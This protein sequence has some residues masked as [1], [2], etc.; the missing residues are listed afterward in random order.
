MPKLK[1]TFEAQI[2]REFYSAY[3]YLSLSTQLKDLGLDGFA[4]W[5]RV[6]AQEEMAHATHMYEY[7]IDRWEGIRLPA[8]AAPDKLCSTPLAVFEATLEHE[9]F[10][11]ANINA[12]ASVAMEES[13]HAAYSFLTWYTSEQVEEESNAR[14]LI[15]QLTLIGDNASAL[16]NLDKD[17]AARV[18]I[19]P[20]PTAN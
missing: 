19:N 16:L 18:F 15:Q 14:K 5:M 9:Q 13:D 2:N 8:I 3:L 11:T 7:A 1:Q 12:L 10:V 17:L 20:F 6:Q 4:N